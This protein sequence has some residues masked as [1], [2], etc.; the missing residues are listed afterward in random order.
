MDELIRE[1]A[2][3][4]KTIREWLVY[5]ELATSLEEADKLCHI[6]SV[7]LNGGLCSNAYLVPRT[8]DTLSVVD[9]D[10]VCMIPAD[11]L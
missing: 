4:G 3:L 10:Y 6:G 2:V 5:F 7:R 9:L 1:K 11:A 8:G